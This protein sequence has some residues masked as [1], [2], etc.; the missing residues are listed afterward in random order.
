MKKK[1]LITLTYY[2]P[3]LSGLTIAAKNI[4]ELLAANNYS[5]TVLTSQ[6]I[7]TLPVQEIYNNV[8]IHR[9]PYL[10]R[11]SKGFIYKSFLKNVIGGVRK[12]DHVL[13]HLPQ[14]EGVIIAVIAKLLRKK[15]YC[16]YHCSVVLGG[17]IFENI[18]QHI[19]HICNNISLQLADTIIVTSDDFARH[20]SLLKKFVNKTVSV[21][22]VIKENEVITGK[23]DMF[24]K[25]IGK[26]KYKIGFFG[27]I[28]REKGIEYLLDTIPHLQ[29][30]FGDDFVILLAGDASSV[31]EQ[32]YA[33]KILQKVH[34]SKGFAWYIGVLSDDEVGLFYQALDV[35]VVPSINSTEAFG[36][37]QVEAMLLGVPVIVSDLP[38]VRVCVQQTHMG[39]IVPLRNSK[40]IADAC[41]KILK[42]PDAYRKAKHVIEE[43]FSDKKILSVFTTLF[44]SEKSSLLDDHKQ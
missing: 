23:R 11:L 35:L 43:E 19:L 2:S 15:L 25:K 9:M 37:V 42:K 17:N 27:R 1:I 41:I 13:I 21:Y 26:A 39:E 6:H 34:G 3:H 14:A 28:A 8:R 7:K 4:A 44:A 12:N 18:I 31:G 38:G 10:F 40:A 29:K 30:K 33:K 20:D 24:N 5:V 32:A 16:F 22:P 36:M